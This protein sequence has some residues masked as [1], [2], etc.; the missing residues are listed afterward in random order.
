MIKQGCNN[1][2]YWSVALVTLIFL[3]TSCSKFTNKP[4]VVITEDS[5][6]QKKIRD[7]L[8]IIDADYFLAYQE[9][10]EKFSDI[11]FR[12]IFSLLGSPDER[13]WIY[14]K[15]DSLTNALLAISDTGRLG[16]LPAR[17]EIKNTINPKFRSALVS[18]KE[19]V[20]VYKLNVP[21]KITD[22]SQY[23]NFVKKH[24]ELKTVL[25]QSYP[26]IVKLNPDPITR[27]DDKIAVLLYNFSLESLDMVDIVFLKS[28]MDKNENATSL[29]EMIA[30]QESVLSEYKIPPRI[31]F[32]GSNFRIYSETLNKLIGECNK[33]RNSDRSN[34]ELRKY[35]EVFIAARRNI[36][37][38]RGSAG[39]LI[40]R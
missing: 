36:Y 37:E 31:S 25:Q 14:K 32:L 16:T 33:F 23:D 5:L 24:L 15:A 22:D 21:G 18:F 9:A 30:R 2:H 3:L 39:S 20:N 34:G 7:S 4:A 38:L 17:E 8:Q 11:S 6:T 40:G 28:S 12:Y 26:E 13:E 10:A 27:A 29:K 19:L 35:Y 1:K